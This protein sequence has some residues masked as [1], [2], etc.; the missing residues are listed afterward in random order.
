[1]ELDKEFWTQRYLD[2]QIGWDLGEV[3]PPL[4]EYI[5]TLLDFDCRILIPGCGNAHEVDY[6]LGRGFKN[7][8]VVDLAEIPLNNL[9]KRVG[10]RQPLKCVC[11]NIF[12]HTGSYDLILEQT[13]FCAIDPELRSKYAEKIASLLVTGGKFVGVLF[14]REFEGGPPFGGNAEEYRLIFQPYF[15][16][17]S[18]QPCLNS[19]KPRAGSE[20]FI[21]FLK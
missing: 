16:K 10:E 4:K 9:R 5:D 3:S 20:V 15:T 14:D 18:I 11:E 17:L 6:L 19:A 1:M 2:K 7:V 13:M 21:E 8:T 12:D